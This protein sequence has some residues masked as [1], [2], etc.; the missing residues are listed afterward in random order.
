M[1]NQT[2]RLIVRRVFRSSTLKGLPKWRID[3]DYANGTALG[4]QATTLNALKASMCD[5]ARVTGREIDLTWFE[6]PAGKYIAD[7]QLVE[8]PI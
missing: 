6:G 5:R 3:A 7:V 4:F 2:D 8:Q 1:N